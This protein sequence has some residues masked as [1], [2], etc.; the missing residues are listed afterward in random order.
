MVVAYDEA[1]VSCTES[2]R[3]GV[4]IGMICS[5]LGATP[6]QI[7]A[8]RATPSLVRDLVLVVHDNRWKALL[9]D[10]IRHTPAERQAE[11]VARQTRFEQSPAGSELAA[12]TAQ[13]RGAIAAA[14]PIENVLDLGRAWPML[15]FLMTG[16]VGGAGSP[17]DLLPGGENIGDE[18]G[19]LG[20]GRACLHD[21]AQTREFSR[22]LAG[23]DVERLKARVD[24]EAMVGL[25]VC[26]M[27]DE[28]GPDYEDELR[29]EIGTDFPRLRDYVGAMADKGNGLLVWVL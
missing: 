25:G 14:G 18:L 27:P 23:Q 13:A 4:G 2:T 9:E 21:A 26:A 28:P 6:P 20:Q 3:S 12:R 22:L 15:H 19:G 8:L 5:V 1:V 11:L 29:E 7:K 17:G 24:L 10:V 16:N